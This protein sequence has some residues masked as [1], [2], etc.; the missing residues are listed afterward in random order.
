MQSNKKFLGFA[1]AIFAAMLWGVSGAF[2]QFLFDKKE[3]NAEWLVTVRLLISGVLM[4]FFGIMQRNP[5]VK[6]IW[7]NKKDAIQLLLF[8]V[9]GMLTVQYTY[10][11]TIFHSNA[12]TATVLQYTGPV[13]IAVYIALRLKKW[14]KPIEFLAIGLAMLGTF[15]MVTHGDTSKLSI[16]PTALIWGM[17]S[18][19]ALAAYTI[20][21]VHL[22]EKYSPISIIGW[23]MLIAGIAMS[24]IHPPHHLEGIWDGETFAAVTFIVFLGTLIPFYIFLTA[25]KNIGPQRA[26]LLACAEPLSATF[27]AITYFGV[28]FHY[29]DW[30]GS[31]CIITTI[32]LLTKIKKK[33]LPE[34][35]L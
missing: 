35:E 20:M 33:V 2:A 25:I 14:P 10:F 13:F 4:L 34:P 18:A 23:S 8:S 3:F 28:Q 31:L 17:A 12:A 29:F 16:N 27:I 6:G 15:L 11:V 22:L 26:S 1:S 9:L 21:P 19:I 30:I 32:L 24:I 5:D 7:K